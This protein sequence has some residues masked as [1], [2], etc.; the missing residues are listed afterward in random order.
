MTHRRRGGRT[1]ALISAVGI[2]MSGC[3]FFA[4]SKS[5]NP[6]TVL[7]ES[8]LASFG[9][10]RDQQRSRVGKRST[11]CHWLNHTTEPYQTTLKPQL[12]ITVNHKVR[13]RPADPDQ[14]QRAGRTASGRSFKESEDD[15][16]CTVTMPVFK[17]PS[18]KKQTGT[19]DITVAM[20]NPT[21]NC[22]TARKMADLVAPKLH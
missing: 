1:I 15:R 6:C 17:E 19:I 2:L 5:V 21:Q 3:S 20:P 12:N 4:T 9:D 22:P 8:E 16:T 11:R 18:R 13:Y 10:Y 14:G 7:T